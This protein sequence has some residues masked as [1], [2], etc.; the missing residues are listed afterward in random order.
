MLKENRSYFLW[1]YE[2]APEALVE[3]VSNTVGSELTTKL[4][5]YA[6]IGVDY[7]IVWDP[8]R[9]LGEQQLHCFIRKGRRF[10]PCE[11]WFPDLELGV[12]LWDGSFGEMRGTFLRWC[13]RHGDVIPTGQERAE[14]ETQRAEQETQRANQLAAKLRELGVDPDAI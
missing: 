11:P 3:V 8:A 7:Y 14:R 12:K 5:A 6:K 2:K 1:K 10:F 4:E 13:D 9:F